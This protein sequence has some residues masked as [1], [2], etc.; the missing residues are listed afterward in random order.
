MQAYRTIYVL[1]GLRR[2]WRAVA[3]SSRQINSF[4]VR[5]MCKAG[6]LMNRFL[7]QGEVDGAFRRV[8]RQAFSSGKLTPGMCEFFDLVTLLVAQSAHGALQSHH[9]PFKFKAS[10]VGG[11]GSSRRTTPTTPPTYRSN[12][13]L[14][15]NGSSG[16]N[17]SKGNSNSSRNTAAV[18]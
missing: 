9:A 6:E 2:L 18:E 10:G 17:S 12:S 15:T 14:G 8:R 11:R 7:T 4:K 13:R 3:G 5:E 16:N 1:Q